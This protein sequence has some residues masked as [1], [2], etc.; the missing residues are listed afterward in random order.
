M[1]KIE[2]KMIAAINA[3]NN[4]HG[5]NTSVVVGEYVSV[6]LHS[7]LIATL[8]ADRLMVTL[9]GWATPTTRS[10]IHAICVAFTKSRGVGQRKGR[11]YLDLPEGGEMEIN[12]REWYSLPRVEGGFHA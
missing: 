12:T 3:G 8:F 5:D 6:F 10:R 9:A 11:Q 2:K 4:F 7:N 1:R